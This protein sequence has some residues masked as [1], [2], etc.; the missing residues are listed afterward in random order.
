MDIWLFHLLGFHNVWWLRDGSLFS[1][2]HVAEVSH[3]YTNEWSKKT[4]QK[5][6]KR[7]PLYL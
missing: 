1:F 5:S 2:R 4:V 6:P 7:M 3:N